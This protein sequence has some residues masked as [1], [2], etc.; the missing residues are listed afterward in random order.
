MDALRKLLSNHNLPED[1]AEE[2]LSEAKRLIAEQTK[3]ILRVTDAFCCPFCLEIVQVSTLA[4]TNGNF[5]ASTSC[6]RCKTKLVV[7]G[8]K[9]TEIL[10]ISE[11][12]TGS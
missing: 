10:K 1:A 5:G 12:I 8:R 6:P 9:T 2:I 3:S 7:T 11:A 4:D